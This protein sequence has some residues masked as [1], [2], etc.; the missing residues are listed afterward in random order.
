MVPPF[1]DTS[2]CTIIIQY[3]T[4]PIA[5]VITIH[6]QF[7]KSSHGHNKITSNE[8]ANNRTRRIITTVSNKRVCSNHP[9]LDTTERNARPQITQQTNMNTA[10]T[11][12]KRTPTTRR[13]HQKQLKSMK[14]T[15]K[16]RLPP[17]TQF[18]L[19]TNI[20]STIANSSPFYSLSQEQTRLRV[21]HKEIT[22]I[23]PEQMA[24]TQTMK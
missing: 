22:K 12:T 4:K 14:K 11:I 18:I 20:S 24:L 2:T 21:Y 16:E 9:D 7:L 15:R 13:K 1:S 5:T 8:D 19:L 6:L 17:H 10:T 3:T 23:T